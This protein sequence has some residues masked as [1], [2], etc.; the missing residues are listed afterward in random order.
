M[1][2]TVNPHFS[3]LPHR[4]TTAAPPP[5]GT[6]PPRVS[7]RFILYSLLAILL[8]S[9]LGLAV[10]LA[11]PHLLRSGPKPLIGLLGHVYHRQKSVISFEPECA[12][13]DLYVTY[14]LKPGTCTFSNRE[15]T[16]RFHINSLGLRDD[17]ASLRA[18]EIIVVGDS[19]A[20][21][22]G[23]DQE[24][25]FAQIIERTTGLVVLNAGIASFGTVREMRL[26]DRLDTS[27]LKYLVVQYHDNDWM[28][29]T[30]FAA[31]NNHL[32]IMSEETYNNLVR[33]FMGSRQYYP[34]KYTLDGLHKI[35]AAL[36]LRLFRVLAAPPRPAGREDVG[37]FLNAL[38][39][40]SRTHL[41]KVQLIVFVANGDHRDDGRIIPEIRRQIRSPQHPGF[42]RNLTALDVSPRLRGD[43]YHPLDDHLNASG[44][45][46]IAAALLEVIQAHRGS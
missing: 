22:W 14:T 13:Y 25:T 34:G 17:E 36:D 11:K 16:N 2:Q 32:P 30:T 12:R 1:P 45:A 23:V 39:H 18:P 6:R 15:F 28:E 26:L 40:A 5:A 8:A 24:E 43:H 10:L 9:E 27:K 38:T 21:G 7:L 33:R 44:H 37:P 41:D 42:I 29:N 4:Q 31:N 20:M 3:L 19:F 46:A 35:L